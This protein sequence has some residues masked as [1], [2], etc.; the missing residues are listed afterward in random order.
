MAAYI[1]LNPV[2][3]GIC[4]DP[5]EYRWSGYAEAVAGGKK[6]RGGL[7]RALKLGESH[8]GTVRAWAQGGFAK[9]YRALLLSAAAEVEVDGKVQRRGMKRKQ[10]EKELVELDGR[11]NDLAISRVIR[12]RVRYFTDGLVIGGREFVDE[13][14]QGCR[15]RFGPSRKSGARKPRGALAQMEGR[16]WSVRDL[17]TGV[18]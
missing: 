8:A 15:E 7:V 6:A 13:F 10:V 3:A 14:F 4:E 1:D 18:G 16:I 2:R 12:H 17:R 9:E 11:K 5:A